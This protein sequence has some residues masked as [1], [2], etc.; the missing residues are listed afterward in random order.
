MSSNPSGPRSKRVPSEA[1]ETLVVDAKPQG[2]GARNRPVLTI[3][4]G[5]A[6]G[7][8]IAL[9]DED[10]ATLGRSE[11]CFVAIP[12]SSLSREHA[13][14]ARIAGVFMFKDAKS[15][16]GSFV[17]GDSATEAIQLKDGDRIQLGAH[18]TLRFSL[19]DTK[20]EEAMK[21]VYESTLRD[22][23]TGLYNRRHLEHQLDVEISAA[24]RHGTPMSVVMLDI[25]HFKNVNDTHGHAAGD[26]VLEA[27]AATLKKIVRPEDFLARY[28]GEEFTLILRDTTTAGA[29]ALANRLRVAI[30]ATPVVFDGTTINITSSSGVASFDECAEPTK[31]ALMKLADERLYA[32]KQGGRNRVV[33]PTGSPPTP[34]S[35]R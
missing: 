21:K 20:E 4:D 24:L 8:V 11:D 34:D 2:P 1:T 6:A 14:I 3:T 28:G 12:D 26:A 13:R 22:A 15:T 31:T 16:N 33:G 35:A 30:E 17:N 19:V 23:L 5:P 27:F 25:D 9:G 10:V 32:A 29:V 18:T 7:R